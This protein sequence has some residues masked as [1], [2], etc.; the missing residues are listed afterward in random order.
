M[1]MDVVG[2]RHLAQEFIGGPTGAAGLRQGLRSGEFLLA[3]A[4]Q[5]GPDFR[6]SQ[7][8]RALAGHGTGDQA[9]G[10]G[11][12]LRLVRRRRHLDH[13]HPHAHPSLMVRVSIAS[14]SHRDHGQ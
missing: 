13:T 11:D 14:F 7:Q 6:Q 12:V 10:L 4:A 3:R 8:I 5:A 2:N 1:Y 9:A